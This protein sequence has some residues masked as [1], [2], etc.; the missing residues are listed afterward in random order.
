MSK[1][2]ATERSTFLKKAHGRKATPVPVADE[3]VQP[4]R[5]NIV[6]LKKVPAKEAA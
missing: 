6:E 4:A 3:E 1:I 5:G 2:H